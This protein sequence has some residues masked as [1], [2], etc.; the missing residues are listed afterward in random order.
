[1]S[2]ADRPAGRL[3]GAAAP[4]PTPWLC[5]RGAVAVGGRLGGLRGLARALFGGGGRRRGRSLRPVALLAAPAAAR[6]R[7]AGLRCGRSSASAAAIS[8]IEPSRSRAASSSCVARGVYPSAEASSAAPTSRGISSAAFTSRAAFSSWRWPREFASAPSSRFASGYSLRRLAVERLANRARELPRPA[9]EDLIG[10][11][12]LPVGDRAQH[13]PDA[14]GTILL[15]RRRLR[16]ERD[17][18]VEVGALDPHRDAV[19]ER[20]QAQPPVRVLR[21]AGREE[22]LERAL[23][24]SRV[25]VNFWTKVWRSSKRI[26]RPAIVAQNRCSSSSRYFGSTRCH[27]RWITASRRRDV[28]RD[29]D[30]PVRRRQLAAGAPLRPPPRR[31]R[32]PRALPVEVGVEQRVERDDALGVRRA[33]R[34]EVDDDPRLLARMDAHDPADPLLVDALRGRRREVH[35]DGRARRVPALGEQHRVDQDVDL[36]ALV[37][38]EDRGEL[39][40]RRPAGDRLGLH[41]RPRGRRLRGCRRGRRRPRRRSPASRRTARGRASRRPCSAPRGRARRRG[42][43]PR[44]RRRRSAPS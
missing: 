1:M 17:E 44:S 33:L 12:G 16:D 23:R 10:R 28:G 36:A 24:C 43:A 18:I 41:A 13:D 40:R 37:G 7:R 22:R 14:G 35:D 34:D 20:D 30:E 2:P 15:P 32:D 8:W 26:W 29:R 5:R 25:S 38:G 11:V 9:G 39:D 21:R 19:G 42:R 6:A 31:R 3:R 27:S 4:A